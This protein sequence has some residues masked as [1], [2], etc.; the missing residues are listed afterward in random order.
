[1]KLFFLLLLCI[2]FYLNQGEVRLLIPGRDLTARR[3]FQLQVLLNG[4]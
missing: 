2:R 3:A 4:S 1:M